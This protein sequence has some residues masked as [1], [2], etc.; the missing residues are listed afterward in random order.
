M[1]FL[2]ALVVKILPANAGDSGD[3]GLIPVLGRAP[4]E[5]NVY[6]PGNSH[7]QRSLL[8]HCPLCHKRVG[9]NLVT[10]QLQLQQKDLI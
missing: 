2:G 4:G 8:G 7:G 5:G 1:S 9:H 6:L 3:I 10:K